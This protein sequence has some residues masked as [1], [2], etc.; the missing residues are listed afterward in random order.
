MIACRTLGRRS[1]SALCLALAAGLSACDALLVDPAGSP[2]ALAL[3]LSADLAA[4]GSADAFD[5]ADRIRIRI[6]AGLRIIQEI[7]QGFDSE[8]G[9]VSVPI[10]APSSVAGVPIDID[11]TLSR[12][13]EV[14]FTGLG[15]L[16]PDAAG[17]NS[18][19]IVLQPVAAGVLIDPPSALF[20][21][22]GETVAFRAVAVFATG[23]TIDGAEI[24]FR[25]I[26]DGIVEVRS[27]GLATARA[28]GTTVVQAAFGGTTADA[29]AR[30]RQRVTEIEV[31]SVPA[32][33]AAGG[34]FVLQS[35]LRDANGYPVQG[36]TVQWTSSD[37]GVLVIDPNNV[38]RA[39][40]SGTVTITG[41]IDDA[42]VSFQVAVSVIPVAPSGLV[43][44]AQGT[45]ISLS[46]QDNADNETGYEVLWRTAGA[47]RYTLLTALPA[48][49]TS[50]SVD[51]FTPDALLE[52][53]VRACSGTSCSPDSNTAATA[54]VPASPSSPYVLF[55][56]YPYQ[57]VWSDMSRAE[58]FFLIERN[59][60]G[61]Y[62]MSVQVPAN[63]TVL[64]LDDSN[65]DPFIFTLRVYACNAAGC[66]APTEE[67]G[68]S[69]GG[70]VP[71]SGARRVGGV[72]R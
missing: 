46:W 25:T 27:N 44:T 63:T 62:D 15:S 67:V 42:S 33:I 4:G 47:A 56:V 50:F 24:T 30:V 16:L 28:E 48:N 21:A 9:D 60:D 43:A 11:V 66:S 61:S 8:G 69:S 18:A 19:E 35:T 1:L 64:P 20:E 12:G 32:S 52:Y 31:A 41:T 13:E 23:D 58:Q 6:R 49:A 14:L 51:T 57:L 7:E 5:A 2:V 17:S 37:P 71:S 38:A 54:T 36:R 34:S 40:G 70:A 45:A 65:F 10:R 26:P 29:E 39:V 59:N 22:F 53:V 72:I 55:D 3:T 68:Y